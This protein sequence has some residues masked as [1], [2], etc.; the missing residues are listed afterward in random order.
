MIS[1]ILQS[2]KFDYVEMGVEGFLVDEHRNS[3]EVVRASDLE[4][5][6]FVYFI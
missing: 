1:K 6:N 3:I 4:E 2:L 5:F